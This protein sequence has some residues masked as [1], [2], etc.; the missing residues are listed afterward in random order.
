MK[1]EYKIKYDII[2]NFSSK[3]EENIENDLQKFLQ[4]YNILL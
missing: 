4:L 3:L 2:A 1:Y